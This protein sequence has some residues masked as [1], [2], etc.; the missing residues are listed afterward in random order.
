LRHGIEQNWGVTAVFARNGMILAAMAAFAAV[1]FAGILARP[2]LPIDET[3]YIGVAW[4]MRLSG[5]W[6]VPQMN[7]EI[8]T[9]KPPLLFWLIN[10]FWAVFGV[11]ETAARLLST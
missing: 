4:E 6:I 9:H 5:D 7:G 8:Y 1:A 10:L 2:V 11:S 3:R